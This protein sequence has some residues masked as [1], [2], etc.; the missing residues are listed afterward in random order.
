MKRKKLTSA[1][2]LAA[3]NVI[4]IAAVMSVVGIISAFNQN[5]QSFSEIEKRALAPKPQ[6]SF[7]S[8]W[9]GEYTR[10]LSLYFAD[11]FPAR[12]SFIQTA[13]LIKDKM[14]FGIGDVKL[15]STQTGDDE[16][17]IENA[18]SASG[19]LLTAVT[20]SG[21]V[22]EAA[23]A[24]PPQQTVSEPS[25]PADEQEEGVRI[26]S[27][28]SVGGT[29]YTVF[30][31]SEAMG[32]WY[33]Q[34]ISAYADA[35]SDRIRVYNMVV[36]TSIEFYLPER[37]R[38][39]TTPQ[40]PRLE[41]IRDNLSDNVVWVDIY[42]ALKAHKDE[43]LFFRTDHHWTALGAY[44]AY[45]Q[46]ARSAGFE[47]ISLSGL[48]KRTLDSFLGTLYSQTQDSKMAKNPDHVDYYIFPNMPSCYM[49]QKNAP[50]TAVK[51][52]LYGEYANSY[53]A[54]S[55]FLHGDFPMMVIESE[56][57]NG[58]VLAVIKESYGNAI[59]PFLTNNYEKIVVIDQR[60][61]QRGLY[62]VLEEQGVNE[63]L[64]INNILAAHTKVR[65]NELNNLPFRVYTPPTSSDAENAAATPKNLPD[66][67]AETEQ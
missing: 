34:I 41:N 23:D 12:D 10:A 45:T 53:N 30:S 11:T 27:I 19:E 55:V 3:V 26:G 66:D 58:R 48:E 56:Q 49:Y 46:L 22:S 21:D 39:I 37:Y 54:Y 67:N 15:Y 6:F 25:E 8:L 28:F 20:E 40:K 31:G 5:R 16:A 9:S 52:P 42:D 17:D 33:A 50:N 64:F 4:L 63:L 18:Q 43:Y 1:V 44:Y 13:S 59:V 47:P 35:L 38:Q 7:G 61:L 65:L 14:G 2:M 24:E 32:K 29:G 60:Y 57:K 62:T 36:P 51:I